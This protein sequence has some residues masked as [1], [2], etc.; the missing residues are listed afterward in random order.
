MG[1]ESLPAMLTSA[2]HRTRDGLL[3]QAEHIVH[4][5]RS[6]GTYI[7]P[8][9]TLTDGMAG[10]Q[11]CIG[12]KFI[13]CHL[14]MQKHIMMREPTRSP[15][16]TITLR[17]INVQVHEVRVSKKDSE[18][19]KRTERQDRR[20]PR[21]HD[22]RT[23]HGRSRSR[24]DDITLPRRD[25]SR[26][27]RIR[28]LRRARAD[29]YAGLAGEHADGEGRDRAAD[30]GG[31]PAARGDQPGLVVAEHELAQEGERVCG[32]VERDEVPGV[33]EEEVRPVALLVHDTGEGPVVGV[34]GRGGRF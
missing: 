28:R 12:I 23:R 16:I 11:E 22:R 25:S 9:T 18:P 14:A 3:Q 27:E 26:R 19:T 17:Q 7:R 34:P 8:V 6:P 31:A 4:Y 2:S 10:I 5:L 15:S 21:S 24:G 20:G 1:T 29:K 30:D 33:F 13:Q 32:L